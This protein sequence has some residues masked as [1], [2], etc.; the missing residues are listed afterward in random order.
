MTPRVETANLRGHPPHTHTHTHTLSSASSD[1]L[2]DVLQNDEVVALVQR[3]LGSAAGAAPVDEGAASQAAQD[4][5][6]AAMKM[7][8]QDN[9]TALVMAFLW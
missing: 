8:T 6:Q 5:V 7:K 3:R 2:F 4:L 9:V 1:G